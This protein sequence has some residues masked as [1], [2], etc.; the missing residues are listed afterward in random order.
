M[1]RPVV[2]RSTDTLTMLSRC[3]RAATLAGWPPERIEA[4]IDE[5]QAGGIEHLLRTA[6][7]H[8]AVT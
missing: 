1:T 6:E 2:Q 5:M 4:V 7:R 3:W 8:F